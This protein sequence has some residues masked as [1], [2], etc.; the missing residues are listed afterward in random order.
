M[1]RRTLRRD[2]TTL[3]LYL[4]RELDAAQAGEVEAWLAEDAAARRLLQTLEAADRRLRAA[5]DPVLDEPTPAPL[6]RRIEAAAAGRRRAP[7]TTGGRFMAGL[8]GRGWMPWAVAAALLLLV[9]GLPAAWVVSH[10]RGRQDERLALAAEAEREAR[11]EASL[12]AALQQALES[13]ISGE[14]LPWLA[15][16]ASDGAGA[17]QPVRTYKSSAGQWC[18]EYRIEVTIDGEAR[19]ERGIACRAAPAE[20][21]A[22]RWERKVLFLDNL[23]L[24]AADEDPT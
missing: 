16:G 13:T 24:P 21:A 15:D 1:S 12:E 2:E 23:P 22:A 11:L 20:G 3:T 6:L 17:V 5:L 8:S 7:R 9:A 14:S 4:D 19:S 18:R 10:D